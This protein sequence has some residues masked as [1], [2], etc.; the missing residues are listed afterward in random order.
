[1]NLSIVYIKSCTCKPGYT[2]QY[3]ERN[4]DECLSSPCKNGGICVDGINSYT[5]RCLSNFTGSELVTFLICAL[6]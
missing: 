5:C 1:M 4:V 3:C 6:I 2:G